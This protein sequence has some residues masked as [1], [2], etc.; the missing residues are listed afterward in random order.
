M[1]FFR[2]LRII[3]KDKWPLYK[4]ICKAREMDF[5]CLELFKI[6]KSMLG[7]DMPEKSLNELRIKH[8]KKNDNKNL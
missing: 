4:R 6:L 1:K 2:K 5:L 3:F 8:Q 7:K